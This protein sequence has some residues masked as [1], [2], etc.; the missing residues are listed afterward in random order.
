MI[1][2][3]LIR[4]QDYIAPPTTSSCYLWTGASDGKGRGK[5]SIRGKQYRIAR[6]VYEYHKGQIEEGFY[7]LHTCDNENCVNPRHLEAGTQSDNMKDM[8]NKQRRA[9]VSVE[10]VELCGALSIAE[11][12]TK[13]G[14]YKRSIWRILV[15]NRR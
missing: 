9:C 12:A 1:V 5:V 7:V 15:G 2:D 14:Y 11:V 3:P 4:W 13:Y 6:L 8:Y 10:D